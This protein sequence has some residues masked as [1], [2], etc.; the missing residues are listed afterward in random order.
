M[1]TAADYRRFAQFEARG[2]SAIYDQ[3]ATGIADDAALLS[4]IDDLPPD[5]RQPNLVLASARF[6]GIAPGP[7][8]PFRSELISRWDEVRATALIRRTQ[9]NEPGRCAVL[10]P[11]LGA[12]PSPLALLEVGASAGLCLYPDRYS[13][14]YSNGTALDPPDGRS[15]VVL[16]CAVSGPVPLPSA[17]PN[18]VWR[19][20]ID[21][22]PLDAADAQDMRWLETLVW[23]EQEH[24]RDRL[25]RA[26]RVAA[27]DPPRLMRGDIA[28]ALPRLVASAPPEATLVV[29]HSAVLAYVPP[30]GREAFAEQ[31]SRTPGHWIS[32]E[33][34]AVVRYD[35]LPASPDPTTGSFVL[36][37][38]GDPLAY[39][40]AHGQSLQW[41][42]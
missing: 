13:Y 12:L 26:A 3:W 42:A 14:R 38:D 1:D 5:N 23:P 22:N 2:H 8:A 6:I 24:R 34:P 11:L 4:L 35:G 16:E 30:A 37:L 10:Q 27:A 20:G 28:Q 36:A 19:A 41:F 15:S 17:L 33:G 25:R 29:F 31:I 32:N 7:F 21:L 39:T 9:T 18:V 40:G